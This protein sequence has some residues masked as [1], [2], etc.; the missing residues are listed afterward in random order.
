MR[1][2]QFPSPPCIVRE[3][4]APDFETLY[5]IDQ[6]CYPRAV[7]YTRAELRWYIGLAGGKCLVAEMRRSERAPAIAGFAVTIA[8]GTRGHIITM[9]VVEA[10]RRKGVGSALLR[11]A[12]TQMAYRGVQEIRL[13]T[14]VDNIAGIAF[15]KQ[16][17][18][19]VRGRLA[20]Y[21]PN[22]TDAFAMSKF[23]QPSR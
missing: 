1:A 15:W 6:L 3:Y 16:H 7:A 21:Y 9:D 2:R 19:H 13:E 14:A 10:H 18:Y 17:D 12:E 8:R 22:G 20:H 4:K 5:A 11:E 23:L